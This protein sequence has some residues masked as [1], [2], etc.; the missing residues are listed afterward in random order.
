M[1]LTWEN[2]EISDISTQQ[3]KGNRWVIFHTNGKL[4]TPQIKNHRKEYLRHEIYFFRYLNKSNR[5]KHKN[6]NFGK[7][8]SN[9]SSKYMYF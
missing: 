2:I 7:K 8:C 6:L 5:E 1:V 3:N 9:W 4:P